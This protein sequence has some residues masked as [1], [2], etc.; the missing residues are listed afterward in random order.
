MKG[1]LQHLGNVGA[2]DVEEM[3]RPRRRSKR[4]ELSQQLAPHEPALPSLALAAGPACKHSAC[5]SGSQAPPTSRQSQPS[6]S[7]SRTDHSDVQP[8]PHLQG[9]AAYGPPRQELASSAQR[10]P[11]ERPAT[12]AAHRRPPL[13]EGSNAVRPRPPHARTPPPAGHAG[14][15]RRRWPCRGVRGRGPRRRAR[16]GRARFRRISCTQDGRTRRAADEA[17]LSKRASRSTPCWAPGRRP[18]PRRARLG[19]RSTGRKPPVT[20]ARG[21]GQGH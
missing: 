16:S 21:S 1:V 5:R 19:R 6:A 13:A 14:A 17:T 9:R 7:V 10:R 20:A 3:N 11:A 15:R 8:P 4:R 2:E 12:T 18:A